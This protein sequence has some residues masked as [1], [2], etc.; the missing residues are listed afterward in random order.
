MECYTLYGI[1]QF[2][3]R[4][5][6]SRFAAHQNVNHGSF[7]AIPLTLH[8]KCSRMQQ[9]RVDLPNKSISGCGAVGSAGGLGPSGRRFETCHSD[10]YRRG[11]QSS[12]LRYLNGFGRSRKG[13][14]NE[15]S[16][17]HFIRPWLFRRKASPAGGAKKKKHPV[18][19][20]FSFDFR[21]S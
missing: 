20:L 13:G 21:T 4:Q 11:A 14:P 10:Q 8:A 1:T 6:F 7:D 16:G 3:Q 18:V 2:C 12:P 5:P 17:G 9:W 15:V 19:V